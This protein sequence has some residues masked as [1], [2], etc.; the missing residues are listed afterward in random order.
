MQ[1]KQEARAH[2]SPRQPDALKNVVHQGALPLLQSKGAAV[3]IGISEWSVKLARCQVR[4]L[5][6]SL[7]KRDQ[8]ARERVHT[9]RSG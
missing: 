1:V 3:N 7:E 6:E 2:P 8:V 5:E 4:P 9:W